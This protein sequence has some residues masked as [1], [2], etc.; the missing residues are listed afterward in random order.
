MG[1]RNQYDFVDIHRSLFEPPCLEIGS[2]LYGGMPSLRVLFPEDPYTGAD[3]SPGPGV[4]VVVDFTR[5]FEEVDAALGGRRFST[6]FCMSVLEHC[7]R[8]WIMA[9]SMKRLLWPGGRICVSA[10]F[11]WKRHDFP[12]DYWRFTPDGIKALFDDDGATGIVEFDDDLTL[13]HSAIHGD[14]APV[15]ED[16][17]RLGLRSAGRRG[18]GRRRLR[19][20]EIALARALSALGPL[21]WLFRHRYVLPPTLVTMVGTLRK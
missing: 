3:M 6:I 10:P 21:R 19:G 1:D 2:R 7:A 5:P 16:L 20:A 11:A 17:G 15:G 4:D 12:A 18:G 14:C 9:A 13:R 8:P